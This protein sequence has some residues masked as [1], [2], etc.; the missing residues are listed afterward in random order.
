[1]RLGIPLAKKKFAELELSLLHL[2]RNVQIPSVTLTLHPLIQQTIEK[3]AQQGGRKPTV[4]A[5]GDIAQDTAFLNKL[6]NEVNHWIR[7]VQKVTKLDRDPSS[8]TASQEIN[9]WLNKEKALLHI[10]EMLK[11]PGIGISFFLFH[12]INL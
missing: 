9:F 8:G 4:E 11:S 2:Q 1:M 5:V 3:C 7:E 6:Q 12:F 10:D